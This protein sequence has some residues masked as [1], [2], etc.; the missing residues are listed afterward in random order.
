MPAPEWQ[1]VKR[2]PSSVLLVLD[3]TT[4]LK[5]WLR[6]V[7]CALAM[8]AMAPRRMVV[9]CIL[10]VV[11]MLRD[12]RLLFGCGSENGDD[13]REVNTEWD[14]PSFL[15]SPLMAKMVCDL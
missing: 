15:Y 8:V 12:V 13:E 11:V 9:N 14:R 10:M 3:S 6:L 7:Y 4:R 5:A 2:V 1:A